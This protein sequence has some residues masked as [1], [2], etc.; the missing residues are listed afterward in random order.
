MCI[1]GKKC[2][3]NLN[4]NGNFAYVLLCYP[5]VHSIKEK[6]TKKKVPNSFLDGKKE[7]RTNESMNQWMNEI[8]KQCNKRI[9][10]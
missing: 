10:E 4:S 8:R 7:K 1:I 2:R 5:V 3:T 6:Y 9:E